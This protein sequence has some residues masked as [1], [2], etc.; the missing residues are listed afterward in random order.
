[1]TVTAFFLAALKCVFP[2][3]TADNPSA[4]APLEPSSEP[5]AF[6]WDAQAFHMGDKSYPWK[7]LNAKPENGSTFKIDL[8]E[9]ANREKL[10][11]EG[12]IKTDA[13]RYRIGRFGQIGNADVRTRVDV[14]AVAD[15]TLRCYF[16]AS[17][18]TLDYVALPMS[19]AAKAGK[20]G[21]FDIATHGSSSGDYYFWLAD[22]DGTR[23]Y[24]SSCYYRDPK[25][26]FDFKYVWTDAAKKIMHVRSAGWTDLDSEYTLRVSM[27]DFT[28]DT[29]GSWSKSVPTGRLWGER[30]YEIDVSDLPPGFYWAHVDYLDRG[31]KVIHSDRT[32]YMKP[33]EK[34]P[35]EDT[36]LGAEDTVPPPWTKPEFAEDGVFKCWNRTIRLGGKGLVSSIVNGGKELL[37][38][39]SVLVLDGSP[40]SFDVRLDSRRNS[41]ATYVLKAREADVTVKAKCEFDGFLLFEAS[42]PT[43]VKSLSWQISAS[44]KHVTG[45]DDCSKEDN[46]NIL[47][48]R[49][50]NPSFHFDPSQKQMWWMPGR[51]G[52]MGG[53]V[54]LRGWHVRDLAKA[55]KVESTDGTITVTTTFVD[56]PMKPG[57]HRTVRFYLEPTPVKPKDLNLAS[58]DETERIT[59]TGHVCRYFEVKYPGFADELAFKPFRDALKSGKRVFFYN[60]S[61]GVSPADPFWNWYRADWNKKGL[62]YFAH[63]APQYDRRR[64]NK[65]YWAYGCLN[66]KSFFEYKLWG[67]NWYLNEP[68]PEMKDLYF[69]LANPGPCCNTIHGCAWK[70]DFGRRIMDW[71]MLSTRELHKRVYRLVKAKNPDGAMFGHTSCRRGP[72]DVFF[73]M[74]CAGE[75]FAY[76][77]QQNNYTYYDVFTPEVMQSFFVPRAQEIVM[78]TSPQLLR[79]REC[80]APHLYK[81]YRSDTPENVRAIR[82]VAAYIKIHDLNMDRGPN[83]REGA[84]FYKVDSAIRRLRKGG[85]HSAYYLD[86]EPAVTVSNPHPRFL[87][88]WFSNGSNA[89]LILL[90][91]TDGEMAQEVSVKGLSSVGTE[92]LD[93]GKFDFTSGK[94]KIKFPPRDARFIAFDL[95]A[96]A[97]VPL[98]KISGGMA[99]EWKRPV[100]D[101]PMLALL[102]KPIRDKVVVAT[103]PGKGCLPGFNGGFGQDSDYP[104]QLFRKERRL[105]LARYPNEGSL[106]ITDGEVEFV[107]GQPKPKT[108]KFKADLMEPRLD[109]WV[110]EPE[111]WV[112]GEWRHNWSGS[113]VKVEAVDPVGKTLE[114]GTKWVSYGI[115]KGSSQGGGFRVRNAFSEI[116]R[117]GEWAA[118]LKNR[119]IYLYPPTEGLEGI[120]ASMK[121]NLLVL[122]G[123]RDVVIEGKVFEN[124][125]KDAIILKN[126]TNVVIRRSIVRN[127]GGWGIKITGGK[128]CRVLG[129]D[130]YNTGEGGVSMAGGNRD[131][132][133]PGNHAVE[134]CHLHHIGEWILHYR[135]AVSLGGVGCRCAHN[136]IHDLRHAAIIYGGN[137]QYIGFNIIHDTCV[138]NY[139]CGALY[140]HTKHDWSDRGHL[141]EY[142]CIFMTGSRLSSICTH[143]IYIDGWSSGVTVRG[144]IVNCASLGLFQNGGN[145]NVYERNIVLCCERSMRRDNLGLMG[146]KKPYPLIKDGRGSPF[147]K[148]LLGRKELFESPLWR[149]RY[150]NM[151]RVLEFEDPIYAHNSLFTVATNNV[152]CWS[153]SPAFV[154]SDQMKG[155]QTITNNVT[156]ADPGFIDYEGFNWELR[157]DSPARKVVGGDSRFGEM[158]LYASPDRV[159][160]PVKFGEGLAK[161]MRT[162]IYP[163]PMVLARV[164]F[165]NLPST[166]ECAVACRDCGVN[167]PWHPG[168]KVVSALLARPPLDTGWRRYEFSFT[169]TVDT[170]ATLYLEGWRGER[171]AYDDVRVTGAEIVNGDFDSEGGWERVP[172]SPGM[173]QYGIAEP[174]YGIVESF[175][176]VKPFSGSR[177]CLANFYLKV[178]QPQ[179]VLKKGVP[180]TVSFVACPAL[181][182]PDVNLAKAGGGN[183]GKR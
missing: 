48:P 183:F 138:G 81:T 144:N 88:A 76:K 153:G 13:S 149:N 115:S 162:R 42:F 65:S 125:R 172:I 29:L 39:P 14:D 146:G 87:W 10:V 135:P 17:G 78:E 90:N 43:T 142:N 71:T 111:L 129:C 75:G 41:D 180:V 50:A 173:D 16:Y 7:D 77:V 38:A 92:I 85:V 12:R 5:V 123:A 51:I 170:T 174:P 52:T 34:M 105:P 79:S 44:R 53:I 91:D 155:F 121:D 95:M 27:K 4:V 47:F 107:K 32:P 127:T 70:D 148:Y 2:V 21:G 26:V 139:D 164:I 151:L 22:V 154:D 1:M 167:K 74:I 104:I 128:D 68:V 136:L 62:D 82:H 66:S 67:V 122:D 117:P 143:G 54:D 147:F 45:F 93:K 133:E 8:G 57:P 140:A 96:S 97:E 134:N 132:L 161:P 58:M 131:R 24:E 31:G 94:C 118:D 15:G 175:A 157:P 163:P 60:G 59:W 23:L 101:D 103:V 178:R 159:S 102:P 130:I 179:I 165:A 116:D 181:K 158:G 69:D 152:W 20:T 156:L 176:G 3:G 124:C 49:N 56:E 84:Q 46:P 28:S 98:E 89:V 145:D 182:I 114:I 169:P 11:L 110:K 126:C 9:T 55:G 64:W 106:Y 61:N 108:V 72:S 120:E 30:E 63:E 73:D 37:S 40:L 137:D 168:K 19:T 119:R 100:A 99:L 6:W 18:M 177:M 160:P 33:A 166:G 25:L 113:S 36:S 141:V 150:P 83:A 112:D 80:W 109:M 86:G 171:T 35:W